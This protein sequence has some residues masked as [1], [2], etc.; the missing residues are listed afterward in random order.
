MQAAVLSS[1]NREQRLGGREAG[2]KE[3]Q[4]SLC[5]QKLSLRA[6]MWQQQPLQQLAYQ[7]GM[8]PW[9]ITITVPY[10]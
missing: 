4:T 5:L 8:L 2:K 1:Y 6:V 9:G 10:N 3:L 7:Q